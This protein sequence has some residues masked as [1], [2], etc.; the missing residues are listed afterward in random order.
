[1]KRRREQAAGPPDL[2]VE[3]VAVLLGGWCAE[4]PADVPREPHGFGGGLLECFDIG[5]I[6]KMWRAHEGWL[7]EQA[8]AWGWGPH[9]VGPDGTRRFYGEALAWEADRGE[10]DACGAPFLH[11]ADRE[12]DED[13]D[14]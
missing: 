3:T 11:A 13:A 8:T 2:Q 5:G 12:G 1:M 10:P 6:A 9:Y 7:R 14:A 4:P